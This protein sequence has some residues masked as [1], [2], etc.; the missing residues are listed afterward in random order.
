[1][2]TEFLDEPTG[3]RRGAAGGEHIV[4]DEHSFAGADGISSTS[5]PY[6]SEYSSR[7][8]A[9]GSLPALRTGTNP[10]RRRYA[11]GAARM[12]PRASMPMTR[13]TWRSANAATSWSMAVA[14]PG[15]SPSSGVMSRNVTPGWG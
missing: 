15:P 14:K 13:S 8:T 12:N 2:P 11:T 1:M 10:A 5:A 3:G 7:T 9:Q 4:D 6:S